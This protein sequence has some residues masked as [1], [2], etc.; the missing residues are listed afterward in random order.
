MRWLR[1]LAPLI[2]SLLLT[3]CNLNAL[4][5][6]ASP[7]AP[8]PPIVVAVQGSN[9]QQGALQPYI[10]VIVK[11]TNYSSSPVAVNDDAF[12]VTGSGYYGTG[13]PLSGDPTSIGL[14]PRTYASIEIVFPWE[15]NANPPTQLHWQIDRHSGSVAIAP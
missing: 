5:Q 11:V 13:Q 8:P 9:V 1:A 7:A 10:H 14:Q 15:P 12:T 3:G 6:Y 2:A 4:E